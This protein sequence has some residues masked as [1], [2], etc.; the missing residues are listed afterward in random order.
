M[1]ESRCSVCVCVC[2][3]VC[4]SVT[5]SYMFSCTANVEMS[6]HIFSWHC[7]YNTFTCMCVCVCVCVCERERERVPFKLSLSLFLSRNSIEHSVPIYQFATSS[8]NYLRY[9]HTPIHPPHPPTHTHTHT[10]MRACTHTRACVQTRKNT[11]SSPFR[12]KHT[13]N[14]MFTHTWSEP[15]LQLTLTLGIKRCPVLC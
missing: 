15:S 8:S 4:V 5:P 11:F 2:V 10:H 7:A 1:C 12:P 6:E 9:K 3:C 13:N 14:H